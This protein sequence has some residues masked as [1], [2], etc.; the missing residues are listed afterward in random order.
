MAPVEHLRELLARLP[1]IEV[2]AS[3]SPAE[4]DAFFERLTPPHREDGRTMPLA[5]PPNHPRTT[6]TEE[7]AAAS[8]VCFILVGAYLLT[9]SYMPGD[10]GTWI[11]RAQLFG[12]ACS[13]VYL[14][15]RVFK[16]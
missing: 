10:L 15:M 9:Q 13:L 14:F 12:A 4:Q 7:L 16:T 11:G 2:F 6:R 3:M 5:Q 1:P 8:A